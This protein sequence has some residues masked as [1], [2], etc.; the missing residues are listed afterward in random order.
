MLYDKID[1]RALANLLRRNL[2]PTP[3]VPPGEF[4]KLQHLVRHCDREKVHVIDIY[5]GERNKEWG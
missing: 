1:A 4:R 3:Y 2:L 5:H